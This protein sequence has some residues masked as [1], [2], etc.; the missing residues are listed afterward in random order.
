MTAAQAENV[1]RVKKVNVAGANKP[2]W[3]KSHVITQENQGVRTYKEFID[4][5]TK[6]KRVQDLVWGTWISECWPPSARSSSVC[7]QSALSKKNLCVNPN[8]CLG[9]CCRIGNLVIYTSLD[10]TLPKGWGQHIISDIFLINLWS[11]KIG[12][13]FYSFLWQTDWAECSNRL[14]HPKNI[15]YIWWSIWWSQHWWL[16]MMMRIGIWSRQPW[17]IL[18]PGWGSGVFGIGNGIWY[19]V[20]G[21]WYLVFGC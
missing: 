20:F 15:L 14:T 12:L 1:G 6:K 11:T 9:S 17:H 4:F 5:L 2:I 7:K 10:D 3:V 16:E 21:I 19:L 8:S 13:G 18:G